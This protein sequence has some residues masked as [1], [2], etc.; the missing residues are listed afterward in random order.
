MAGPDSDGEQSQP[1]R[2]QRIV[3]HFQGKTVS[4]LLELLVIVPQSV[5]EFVG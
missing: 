3:S 2:I 1:P 5:G 4:G